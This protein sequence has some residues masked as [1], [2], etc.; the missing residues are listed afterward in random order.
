[1]KDE[2]FSDHLDLAKWAIVHRLA[3]DHGLRR[4]DHIAFFRRSAP[5]GILCGGR[6]VPVDDAVWS[7][8]RDWKRMEKEALAGLEVRIFDKEWLEVSRTDYVADAVRWLGGRTGAGLVLLD[9]DTGLEPD[10]VSNETHVLYSEV[11]D[12]WSA[13]N[14]GD[15]LAIYQHAPRGWKGWT[16]TLLD[17]RYRQLADDM[18]G[19]VR[20]QVAHQKQEHPKAAIFW[21]VKES[22][23]D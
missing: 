1:M 7:Y 3:S 18:D 17:G 14:S 8:F 22:G 10:K 11:K 2:W 5:P 16:K 20:F 4:V 13:L 23:S 6:T 15:V 19:D 9:P 12:I 21:A